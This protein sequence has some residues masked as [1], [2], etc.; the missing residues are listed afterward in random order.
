MWLWIVG[1]VVLLGSGAA[2]VYMTV[3]LRNKNP[4]NLRKNSYLGSLGVDNNG[5]AIFDTLENGIRAIGK[6]LYL[7]QARG[8][9]TIRSLI[10]SWAP[11]SENDTTAYIDFVAGELAVDPE[12]TIDVHDTQ[13]L[14][15][16]TRAIIRQEN[17]TLP[18]LTI[19]DATVQAGLRRVA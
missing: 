16:L 11:P 17:G 1:A 10:S 6:Q 7:N 5:Y 9:H 14:F 2:A 15:D 8:Q 19:S 3:G 13:T 4:G 18:A 12:A